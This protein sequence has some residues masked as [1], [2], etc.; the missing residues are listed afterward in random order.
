MK[1]I[2]L[3][4]VVNWWAFNSL[5]QN[6]PNGGFEIVNID[7]INPELSYPLDWR[8]V[9]FATLECFPPITQGEIT[10]E[11]HNGNWAI[12][13]QTEQCAEIGVTKHLPAGYVTGN[14]G[15]FFPYNYAF[16]SNERLESLS[17]FYKFQREGNDS[18]FVEILL[19]NY[20]TL[21]AVV[22]DTIAYTIEYIKEGV[23]EYT[24][25]TIPVDYL[26]EES[27]DFIH[28]EFGSGKNCTLSSCTPGTTF[29]VDDVTLSGGT[30][31]IKENNIL[32][33]KIHLYP[34]PTDGGVNIVLDGNAE[35]K[36]LR[37]YSATGKLLIEKMVSGN[38]LFLNL[39]ELSKG[40]YLMEIETQDGIKAVKQLIVE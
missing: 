37:V 14:S 3:I 10:N 8:R 38:P 19:F 11:S 22:S 2:L 9:L 6:V 27:P 31:G 21:Q 28:I 18:A 15:T 33:S 29:W 35:I 5:A 36:K 32:N 40:M 7:S 39:N 25:M 24:L 20:D 4:L 16:E 26:I 17:F 30:I 23:E 13:M 1:Y 34:N 12:L